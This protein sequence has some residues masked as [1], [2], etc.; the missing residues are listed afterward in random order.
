MKKLTAI[1]TLL[2]FL[3]CQCKQQTVQ[4]YMQENGVQ[5]G[6]RWQ[7]QDYSQWD[8]FTPYYLTVIDLHDTTVVFQIH[9]WH[10]GI[11]EE[12]VWWFKRGIKKI[13][14]I[15]SIEI[16]RRYRGFPNAGDAV[17][18]DSIKFDG[19]DSIA[20]VHDLRFDNPALQE[21]F[22]HDYSFL[23]LRRNFFLITE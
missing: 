3:F 15:D 14:D 1:V 9:G 17:Q 11:R 13:P 8:G 7:G 2:T 5:I 16:G 23:D 19:I 18:V 4:E 22:K 6:D 20:Y 21:M 10:G 12:G